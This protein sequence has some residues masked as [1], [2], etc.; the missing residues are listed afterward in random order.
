MEGE[1]VYFLLVT[2]AVA[3]ISQSGYQA[4]KHKQWLRL[5]VI[6]LQ[7]IGLALIRAAFIKP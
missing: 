5:D 7:L 3:L 6:V 1:V 2:T 4:C